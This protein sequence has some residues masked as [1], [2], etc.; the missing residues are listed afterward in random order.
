MLD[1]DQRNRFINGE[2]DEEEM[3]KLGLFIDDGE[4]LGG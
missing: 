2:M 3:K 4:D 1:E